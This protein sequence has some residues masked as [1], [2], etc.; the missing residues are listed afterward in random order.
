VFGSIIM[1]GEEGRGVKSLPTSFFT[2]LEIEF[3]P[4][5]VARGRIKKSFSISTK[6]P[7]FLLKY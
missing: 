6:L 4:R 7:F 2:P 1:R 3:F 5:R